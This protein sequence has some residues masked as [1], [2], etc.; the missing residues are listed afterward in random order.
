MKSGA[1][2]SALAPRRRRLQLRVRHRPSTAGQTG[3]GA[4]FFRR[5]QRGKT[6]QS[7]E[8]AGFARADMP[9]LRIQA[10][11]KPGTVETIVAKMAEA[12]IN[13]RGV[14]AAAPV[15]VLGDS[16]LRREQGPRQSA[17]L[18]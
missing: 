2:R 5:D 17:R 9:G 7:G 1:S 18:L 10:A 6:V 15:R 3:L 16:G 12:G 4:R 14:G 13:L 11:D 8:A